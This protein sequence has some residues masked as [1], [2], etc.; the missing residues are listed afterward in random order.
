MTMV[1][2]TRW[3]DA[4]KRVEFLDRD[5]TVTTDREQAEVWMIE[6][7]AAAAALKFGG[8]IAEAFDDR[9][10]DWDD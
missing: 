3:N 8:S 9:D 5:G 4:V 7:E 10:D 6:D 1:H 2:V